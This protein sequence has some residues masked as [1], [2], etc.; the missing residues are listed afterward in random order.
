MLHEGYPHPTASRRAKRST[1]PQGGGGDRARRTI[2]AE[3]STT[4]ERYLRYPSGQCPTQLNGTAKNLRLRMESAANSVGSPPPCGEGLGVG[5]C[6]RR[7]P[8][9]DASSRSCD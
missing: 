9:E 1:S 5:V 3:Q 2:C 6:G 7:K 8:A 4:V